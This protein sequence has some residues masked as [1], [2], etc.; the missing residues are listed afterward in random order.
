MG[1]ST[2]NYHNHCSFNCGTSCSKANN[3]PNRDTHDNNN[4]DHHHND[5]DNNDRARSG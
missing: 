2:D 3:T 4:D 5:Y 1:C